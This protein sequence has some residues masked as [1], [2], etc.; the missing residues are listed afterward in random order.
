M[1]STISISNSLAVGIWDEIGG[2]GSLLHGK[3]DP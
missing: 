1:R 3:I 2:S